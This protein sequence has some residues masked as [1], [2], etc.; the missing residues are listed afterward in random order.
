VNATSPRGS[1]ASRDQ[2]RAVFR[3][4]V[5]AFGA[6]II[7]VVILAA[8]TT[9]WI[10]PYDP[11]LVN[12]EQ[13]LLPPSLAHPLGT[14]QSGRDVLARVV[15]GTRTSLQ[16]AVLAVAI[17]LVGGVA[18]GMTAGYYGGTIFEQAAM[19][20]MDAL[21]SIPLL[22]WA[23]AVVGIIG[24][25]P[26]KIG[27]F[28]IPNE[29]RVAILVGAL[30]I[31]AIARV[32]HSVALVESRADY[33]RARRAQ[34]AGD[35]E[36]IAF[37]VLP[38]CMSAVI[39]QATLFIAIG[40]IVEASLSFVGLGVQPPTASWG[41]MLADARGYIFSNEWWLPVFPGLAISI[42]VIG[43]NLLGDALQDSL[44]PRKRTTS[45]VV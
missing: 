32:M 29:A 8:V 11:L 1:A 4:G 35:L 42:T 37:D 30:Y 17:G 22:V 24:V 13:K 27:R 39:V 12:L 3:R 28:E 36:I 2:V 14:D 45:V 40:I 44:D 19:R 25:G 9:P 15:W 16:V 41:T 23:I 18:I 10:V 43:F 31:P 21:S 34:G 6:T 38:N 26:A 20:L 33:V 5:G 7:L